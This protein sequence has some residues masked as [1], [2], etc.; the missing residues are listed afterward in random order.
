MASF[1]V[2]QDGCV[3]LPAERPT[4]SGCCWLLSC[5]C[6]IPHPPHCLVCL[7]V[8]VVDVMSRCHV[9]GFAFQVLRF[10]HSL[11]FF[12]QSSKRTYNRSFK[13]VYRWSAIFIAPLASGESEICFGEAD[14][15]RHHFWLSQRR[16]Q[17]AFGRYTQYESCR[18][19]AISSEMA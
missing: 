9:G 12:N 6:G 14:K 16:A 13:P 5:W 15:E 1:L 8:I 17:R 10:I 2:D 4:G 18:S 11:N 7:A 3:S 19:H